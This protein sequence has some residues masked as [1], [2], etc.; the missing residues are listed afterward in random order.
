MAGPGSAVAKVVVRGTLASG[1]Q[2][3][4]FGFWVL[5]GSWSDFPTQ[6]QINNVRDDM[7]SLV[8]A[9]LGQSTVKLFWDT[10]DSFSS[11]SCYGYAA[12]GT[13][14][15]V[16]ADG[17]FTAIPGTATTGHP[18]ETSIVVSLRTSLPG[19]SGRGRF[20]LPATGVAM[21]QLGLISGSTTVDDLGDAFED[22]CNALQADDYILCVPSFTKSV[23]T[24]VSHYVIDNKPDTQR[25]RMDKISPD[26]VKTGIIF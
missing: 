5:P 8:P 24:A 2:D 18:K 20:Y 25:R 1:V 6:S 17:A 16:L 23:T 26:I 11:V 3:M 21:S 12:T 10:L 13:T 7:V 22:F 4:S 14:A 9:W 15:A 19:R